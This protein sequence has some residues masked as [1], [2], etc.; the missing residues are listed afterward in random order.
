MPPDDD[1]RRGRPCRRRCAFTPLTVWNSRF[2]SNVQRIVP[3]LVRVGAHAAVERAGEH[4]AGNH[5][6]RRALRRAARAAFAAQR[7]L[8]RHA[9][10]DLAGGEIHGA[11]AARVRR[12]QVATRRSRPAVSSTAPPHWPPRPLPWPMRCC[13]TIAPSLS[14]SSA[15]AMPD[16]CGSTS[17][18]RPFTVASDGEAEKS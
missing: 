7:L 10:R 8:R 4:R 11:H 5:R 9:P 17:R 2:V 14:G 13:H 12:Q 16:F 1:R 3:S 18:S 6:D 15:K